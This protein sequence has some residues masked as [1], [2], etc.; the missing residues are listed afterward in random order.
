[1]TA[2]SLPRAGTFVLWT[3]LGIV[4]GLLLAVTVPRPLGHPVL[5]VLTGSMQP[6]V[7]AGDVVIES[8]IAPLDAKVGDIVTFRDPEHQERLITHRVRRV[9]PDGGQVGFTTKGDANNAVETWRIARDGTIGRVEF[10]LPKLGYPLAWISGG[11]TRL[12]LLVVPAVLLGLLELR[13]IWFPNR[14]EV[15]DGSG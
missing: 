14:E 12:L 7:N 3:A 6:E 13:R 8:R 4:T 1:M 15:A 2:P 5:T 10:R 9:Q 11:P